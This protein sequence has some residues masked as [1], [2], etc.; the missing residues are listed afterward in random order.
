[1]VIDSGMTF[2]FFC[3]PINSNCDLFSLLIK[4]IPASAVK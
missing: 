3:L 4:N 1:M 2:K